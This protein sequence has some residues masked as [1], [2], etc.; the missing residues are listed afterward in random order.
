MPLAETV[1]ADFLGVGPGPLIIRGPRGVESFF[2]GFNESSWPGEA[3]PVLARGRFAAGVVTRDIRYHVDEPH[4]HWRQQLFAPAGTTFARPDETTTLVIVETEG[5]KVTRQWA[6]SSAPWPGW[7]TGGALPAWY[8]GGIGM[9]EGSESV[10]LREELGAPA[11]VPAARVQA[12]A[13]APQWVALLVRERGRAID[14]L[15][16][17]N[18]L[19]RGPGPIIWPLESV[20]AFDASL[21]AL[22]LQSLRVLRPDEPIGPPLLVSIYPILWQD[23]LLAVHEVTD[24]GP[25]VEGS[26]DFDYGGKEIAPGITI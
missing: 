6:A 1:S 4:H 25:D 17:P 8:A 12:P 23:G 2:A 18:F 19:S 7:E 15:A 14:F 21:R 22:R 3:K 5:G 24:M 20:R 9:G 11:P 26:L 13:G 10:K 16:A